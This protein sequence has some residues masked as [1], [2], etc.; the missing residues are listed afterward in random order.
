M[1]GI[2]KSA[3]EPQLERSMEMQREMNNHLTQLSRELERFTDIAPKDLP[4]VVQLRRI[5]NDMWQFLGNSQGCLLDVEKVLATVDEPIDIR[6]PSA[7]DEE[8][9]PRNDV[10]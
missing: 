10:K 3:I 4:R 1:A 5:V 7:N 9:D 6:E 2:H 8:I